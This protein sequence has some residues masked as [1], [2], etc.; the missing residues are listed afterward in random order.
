MNT[1]ET[2]QAWTSIGQ[3]CGEYNIKTLFV[4]FELRRM[5]QVN[6]KWEQVSSLKVCATH[7]YS[8]LIPPLS[9]T[10]REFCHILLQLETIKPPGVPA[11]RF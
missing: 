4:S 1:N 10:L 3:L 7:L 9:Y 8:K 11:M 2:E 6:F 5:C